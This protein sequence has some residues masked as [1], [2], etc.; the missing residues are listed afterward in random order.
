[1]SEVKVKVS[2]VR[3]HSNDYGEFVV[4][5]LEAEG[6]SDELGESRGRIYQ[7]LRQSTNLTAGKQITLDLANFKKEVR[8][9]ENP[10]SGETMNLTYLLPVQV[11]SITLFNTLE[12]IA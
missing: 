3:N 1:M 12:L 9:W 6:V 10:E 2:E 5:K 7:A 4:I 8:E 11:V